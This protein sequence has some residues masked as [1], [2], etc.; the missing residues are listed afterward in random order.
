MQTAP[1]Q[2]ERPSACWP[3]ARQSEANERSIDQQVDAAKR[4]IGMMG[5]A[6]ARV[7]KDTISA[8]TFAAKARPNWPKLLKEV[9]EKGRPG[10]VIWIWEPSRAARD[11]EEWAAFL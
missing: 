5:W 6:L 1:S 2:Q 10:D 3:Y 8:S 7:F 11:L 4:R 9:A